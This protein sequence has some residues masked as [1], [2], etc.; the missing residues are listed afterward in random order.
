MQR[1]QFRHYAT[2]DVLCQEGFEQQMIAFGEHW[3]TIRENSRCLSQV[4]NSVFCRL[5]V[6]TN[7]ILKNYLF[8]PRLN[9]NSLSRDSL[10]WEKLSILLSRS[11]NSSGLFFSLMVFGISWPQLKTTFSS[12]FLQIEVANK[13]QIEVFGRGFW[14]L[15]KRRWV[16]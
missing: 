2:E 11:T 9:K 1:L 7:S 4:S 10:T 13:T 12:F 14:K 6:S 15:F 8:L 5:E 3:G 16:T